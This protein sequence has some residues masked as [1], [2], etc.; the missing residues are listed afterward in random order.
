MEIERFL[1]DTPKTCFNS[2]TGKLIAHDVVGM[3]LF[4]NQ[5]CYCLLDDEKDVLFDAKGQKVAEDLNLLDVVG[6]FYLIKNEDDTQSLITFDGRVLFDQVKDVVFSP[7][8]WFMVVSQDGS[9][10]LYRSDL[11]LAA[12]DFIQASV[13]NDGVYFFVEHEPQ[14]WTCYLNDGTVFAQ[15]VKEFQFFSPTFYILTFQDKTVV[16]DDE[17]H[18]QFVCEASLPQL[19]FGKKFKAVSRGN[20]QLYRSDGTLLLFGHKDY[21]SFDNGM[22][23]ARRDDNSLLL[24]DDELNVLVDDITDFE[25]GLENEL[26]KV[27]SN[28][29]DYLFNNAG[30]L[31]RKADRIKLCGQCCFLMIEKGQEA[32]AFCGSDGEVLAQ[33]VLD[34]VVF[35]NGWILLEKAP[36]DGGSETYMELRTDEGALVASSPLGIEYLDGYR[37]W[38]IQTSK[39]KCSLFHAELGALVKNADEI[40]A[41]GAFVIVKKKTGIDIFSLRELNEQKPKAAQQN[42]TEMKPAWH[43]SVQELAHNVSFCSGD[44]IGNTGDFLDIFQDEK[45]HIHLGIGIMTKSAADDDDDDE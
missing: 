40:V 36:G 1:F 20:M 23:M 25:G 43:G 34:A 35:G 26:L 22:I 41:V 32:G 10:A 13:M 44:C 31:F 33:D 19:M 30:K 18:T 11:S 28:G 17:K 5:A 45:M 12:K 14:N 21:L 24:Y 6:N 29:C 39:D 37:A 2:V 7:I 38:I 42:K 16:Y 9:K 27:T 3:S 15:N 4:A 8:G